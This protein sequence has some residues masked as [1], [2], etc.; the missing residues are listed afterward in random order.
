MEDPE[1]AKYTA[2]FGYVFAGDNPPSVTIQKGA[3]N[4]FVS[5]PDWIIGRWVDGVEY[6]IAAG[7]GNLFPRQEIEGSDSY[8]LALG[9][10][11]TGDPVLELKMMVDPRYGATSGWTTLGTVTD[12]AAFTGHT[13]ISGAGNRLTGLISYMVASCSTGSI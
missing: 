11:G 6:F 3:G 12:S 4:E 2:Y 9:V 10:Q 5:R 8:R 13:D 7:N 1:T